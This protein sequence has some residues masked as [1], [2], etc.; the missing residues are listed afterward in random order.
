MIVVGAMSDERWFRK[1]FIFYN[2]RSM[3]LNS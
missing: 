3:I 2:E 1:N